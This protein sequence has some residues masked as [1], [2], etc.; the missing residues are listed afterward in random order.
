MGK[1]A[2]GEDIPI[3]EAFT[4][5]GGRHIRPLDIVEIPLTG[6]YREDR[7]QRENRAVAK[8]GWS[9][10]GHAGLD[11]I[12]EYVAQPDLV[13]FNRGKAVKASVLAEMDPAEWQSLVLVRKRA[14]FFS[15]EREGLGGESKTK[16]RA[17]FHDG[18][19]NELNLPVT[20]PAITERLDY[21]DAFTGEFVLT[22]SLSTPF[23]ETADEQE[24]WCYKIVAAAIPVD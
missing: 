22:V 7:F 11:D 9:R 24:Q 20:D 6:P 10:V 18:D 3:P 2:N 14:R 21:E 1:N 5:I 19:G 17:S 12:E 13:F 8:G 16:K 15:E 23:P 4:R